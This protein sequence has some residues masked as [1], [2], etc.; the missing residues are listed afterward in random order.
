MSKMKLFKCGNLAAGLGLCRTGDGDEFCYNCICVAE[1]NPAKT[2]C[3][4]LI[5]HVL[6]NH[7]DGTN[8]TLT[9]Q[10]AT[11]GNLFGIAKWRIWAEPCSQL[12]GNRYTRLKT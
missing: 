10:Q 5:H 6:K 4:T 3:G 7:A 8:H 11:Q 1:N 9:I 12:G 2:N